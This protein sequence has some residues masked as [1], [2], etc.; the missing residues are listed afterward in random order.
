MSW[1][2]HWANCHTISTEFLTHWLQGDVTAII[3]MQF[4][5]YWS[6]WY[7][8]HML[9]NCT[10]VNATRPS[11]WQVNISSGNI[12]AWY[13]QATSLYLNQCWPNPMLPYG[14]TRPQWVDRLEMTRS[15]P[16]HQQM[17][18]C[19]FYLPQMIFSSNGIVC[20]KRIHV[21]TNLFLIELV[22]YNE[23]WVNILATDGLVF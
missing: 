4:Q 20:S 2:D 11:W 6:N 3:D 22:W 17:S 8:E 5:T 13:C 14:I 16:G 7:I 19:L 9:W 18:C 15:S 23:H 1:H 10:Q 12:M 21:K